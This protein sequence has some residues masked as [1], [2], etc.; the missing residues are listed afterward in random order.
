MTGVLRV[1]SFSSMLLMRWELVF[2][3]AFDISVLL[4]AFC[5]KWRQCRSKLVIDTVSL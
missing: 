2:L 5:D 3:A 1:T 4:S